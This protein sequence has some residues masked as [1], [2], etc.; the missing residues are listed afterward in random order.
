MEKSNGG[1]ERFLAPLR[2][3][4]ISLPDGY[5][6]PETDERPDTFTSVRKGTHREK[7][8]EIHTTYRIL[9]DGEPSR[10]HTSVL[11]DGSVHTH[12]FPQYSFR[13][14]VDLARKIIDASMVKPPPD[15]L[16]AD[17]PRKAQGRE[18]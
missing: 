3:G 17:N 18:Q 4:K 16:G 15:E 8:F 10:A 2:E 5:S 7:T 6:P 11:D 9:I 1:L 14:A 13:S 12:S